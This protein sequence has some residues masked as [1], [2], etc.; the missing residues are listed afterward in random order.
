MNCLKTYFTNLLK[1][2][3]IPFN[4]NKPSYHFWC[5]ISTSDKTYLI[6]NNSIKYHYKLRYVS[7]QCD[8]YLEEF[9]SNVN[10]P[11]VIEIISKQILDPVFYTEL[12][13]DSLEIN[14]NIVCGQKV[15]EKHHHEGPY[16]II[17]RTPINPQ[18]S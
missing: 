16:S 13:M 18:V 14:E 7:F 17:I 9:I 11:F 8:K 15:Q 10:Q 12:D 6:G 1:Y 3:Y 2:I 5:R 4:S